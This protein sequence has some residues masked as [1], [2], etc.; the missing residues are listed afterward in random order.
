MLGQL[1]ILI[2]DR[3]YKFRAWDAA[4]K[5]MEHG[6]MERMGGYHEPMG[7]PIMQYTGLKDKNGV[8]IYEGDIVK[9]FS[10]G[11]CRVLE[12]RWRQEG[13]PPC[14]ILYPAWND[15]RFWNLYGSY[16]GGN[17]DCIDH[18]EVVGNIYENPELLE[19][20]AA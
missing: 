9:A 5:S 20:T 15:G 7:N 12:V 3:E 8:E 16:L 14:Y 17:G 6:G 18:C 4:E 19:K 2:M 11:S 13:S 1:D 10:E